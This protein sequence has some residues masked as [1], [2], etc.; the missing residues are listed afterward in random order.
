MQDSSHAYIS[1]VFPRKNHVFF[2][3]TKETMVVKTLEL[4]LYL[5]TFFILRF[6]QGKIIFF[7][8]QN[9][10]FKQSIRIATRSD[11]A[12]PKVTY[13]GTVLYNSTHNPKY[14][15]YTFN[16]LHH[17]MYPPKIKLQ[18]DQLKSDTIYSTIAQCCKQLYFFWGKLWFRSCKKQ[19]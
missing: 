9:I 18:K 5:Q 14:I 7:K 2:S 4:T 17:Y 11:Q 15:A 3:L 16:E 19:A 6:Q 12:N 8:R 13:H 10:S 1:N